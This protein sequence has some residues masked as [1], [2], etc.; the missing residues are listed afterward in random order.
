MMKLPVKELVVWA[1]QIDE[2]CI[3]D[4]LETIGQT[5]LED[6]NNYVGHAKSAFQCVPGVESLSRFQDGMP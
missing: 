2:A 5:R 4:G 6:E 3:W 1:V